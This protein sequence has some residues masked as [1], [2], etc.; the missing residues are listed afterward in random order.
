MV[1]GVGC[2]REILPWRTGKSRSPID[3]NT[4]CVATGVSPVEL[5][6]PNRLVIF[7]EV[8]SRG[9][10]DSELSG[11]QRGNQHNSATP[12]RGGETFAGNDLLLAKGTKEEGAEVVNGKDLARMVRAGMLS[13]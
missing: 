13:V 5:V 12:G 8:L 7:T 6:T 1:G 10:V 9:E 2:Y 11:F 4:V 3:R